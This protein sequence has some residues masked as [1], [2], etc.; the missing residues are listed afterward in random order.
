MASMYG[1]YLTR[2]WCMIGP[3]DYILTKKIETKNLEFA[4]YQY[5]KAISAIIDAVLI[6]ESIYNNIMKTDKINDFRISN[7]YKKNAILCD[8]LIFLYQQNGWLLNYNLYML[9]LKIYY[10]FGIEIFMNKIMLIEVTNKKPWKILKWINFK[11]IKKYYFRYFYFKK[12]AM[13]LLKED[14]HSNKIKKYFNKFV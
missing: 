14:I 3:Y 2:M 13:L 8:K 11:L 1:V 9:L 4:T 10:Q 5:K 7:Y 6:K 12:I